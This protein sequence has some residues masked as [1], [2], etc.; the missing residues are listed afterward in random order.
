MQAFASFCK[1]FSISFCETFASF[2]KLLQGFYMVIV[3]LCE[4][5]A[6]FFRALASLCKFFF[7]ILNL[8]KRLY[9]SFCNLANDSA[10]F[11]M[12]LQAFTSFCKLHV[13]HPPKGSVQHLP[14]GRVDKGGGVESPIP[15][16]GGC[17]GLLRNSLPFRFS[18]LIPP[19][20]VL[21][22]NFIDCLDFHFFI[23]SLTELG[24][25]SI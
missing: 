8:C 10:S 3:C 13:G 20:L 5:F 16:Q 24:A 22:R 18:E 4:F 9:I 7:K 19:D 2:C 6:S 21:S 14:L 11:C 15:H 1:F 23:A 17:Y 12:L 25:R